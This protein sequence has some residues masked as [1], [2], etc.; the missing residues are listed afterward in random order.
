MA[1]HRDRTPMPVLN[2]T[3]WP[4]RLLAGLL[5]C[6]LAGAATARSMQEV[7]DAINAT[8]NA[9][10]PAVV[11][12]QT[13]NHYAGGS[14]T[15]RL[16]N[17]TYQLASITP[18][19]F[20][21]GCNG[22]DLFAGGF[23]FINSDEM[24]AMLRNIGSSAISYAFN[25]AIQNMCPPCYNIMEAL[26][27]TA[28]WANRLSIDTCQAGVGVVNAAA[29]AAWQRGRI[30]SAKDFGVQRGQFADMVEAWKRVG[31][32]GDA[33]AQAREVQQQ[34]SAQVAADP[35][36]A[37]Q[38]PHGNVVWQALSRTSGLSV[39]YRHILMGLVGTVIFTPEDPATGTPARMQVKPGVG[40]DLARLIGTTSSATTQLPAY[41]CDAAT[42]PP[43]SA[44][45]ETLV[46][47]QSLNY[48]TRQKLEEVRT[49]M[50]ARTP[51]ADVAAVQG[52]LGSV[53]QPVYRALSVYTALGP[54]AAASL[55]DRYSETIAYEYARHYVTEALRIVRQALAHKE[56]VAIDAVLAAKIAELEANL[57]RVER[58]LYAQLALVQ[59]KSLATSALVEELQLA[60]RALH[61]NLSPALMGAVNFARGLAR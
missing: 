52:F 31:G 15:M 38:I 60:E 9:S 17:R 50:A 55:I 21:G 40:L 30:E 23:S 20:A 51:Y 44:V 24:V 8:G 11:Q 28:N 29:P 14:L 48:L 59:Q 47:E 45:T 56:A 22:I 54:G 37:D 36:R 33:T 12:G 19:R 35:G 58:S 3:R 10:A 61:T 42:D 49:H 53:P 5:S 1:C 6:A 57:D 2:R 16:P 34:I 13:L 25:L 39:N 4:A 26:K 41:V 46:T 27:T 32:A 18:P 7:F 43:C